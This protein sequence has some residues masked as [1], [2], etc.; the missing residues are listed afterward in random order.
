LIARSRA[1]R[2]HLLVSSGRYIMALPE[3]VMRLNAKRFGLTALPIELPLPQWHVGI[4]TLAHRP[5]NPAAGKFIDVARE[6]A[7]SM[8]R[9]PARTRAA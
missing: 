8:T 3:S 1:W 7:K 6:V 5:L 2:A 9:Q 4:V